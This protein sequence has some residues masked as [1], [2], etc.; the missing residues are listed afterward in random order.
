MSRG[1][2]PCEKDNLVKTAKRAGFTDTGLK[3]MLTIL[4]IPRRMTYEQY[5]TVL[6]YLVG[7]KF[8]PTLC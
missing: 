6:P 4:N 1:L 2:K 8:A 5:A 3:Y 7:T